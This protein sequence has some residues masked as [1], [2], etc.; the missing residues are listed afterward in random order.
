MSAPLISEETRKNLLSSLAGSSVIFDGEQGSSL[1]VAS[2]YDIELVGLAVSLAQKN[3]SANDFHNIFR[4]ALTAN[5]WRKM[6]DKLQ[7]KKPGDNLFTH[8][9]ALRSDASASGSITGS[10]AYFP[11]GIHQKLSATLA[12]VTLHAVLSQ[13]V[14]V[15][16]TTAVAANNSGRL[17]GVGAQGTGN[18]TLLQN[19]DVYGSSQTSLKATAKYVG[20]VT[21]CNAIQSVEPNA[22]NNKVIVKNLINLTTV[23]GA[24]QIAG[25]PNYCKIPYNLG[26]TTSEHNNVFGYHNRTGAALATPSSGAPAYS[27]TINSAYTIVQRSNAGDLNESDSAGIAGM[28]WFVSCWTNPTNNTSTGDWD[29]STGGWAVSTRY[30]E[31]KTKLESANDF[32]GSDYYSGFADEKAI[33]GL[34]SKDTWDAEK[35]TTLGLT[36]QAIVDNG[37][38]AKLSDFKDSNTPHN[39]LLNVL[40]YEFDNAGGAECYEVNSVAVSTQSVFQQLKNAGYTSH[41]IVNDANSKKVAQGYE[42]VAGDGFTAITNVFGADT[43]TLVERI[44]RLDS[45]TGVQT[46][47]PFN[48]YNSSTNRSVNGPKYAVPAMDVLKGL[49]FEQ[50]VD[51]CVALD[52]HMATSNVIKATLTASSNFP[53]ASSQQRDR[54]RASVATLSGLGQNDQ[55][56]FLFLCHNAAMTN[57]RAGTIRAMAD[58]MK[59]VGPMSDNKYNAKTATEV[60]FVSCLS[61]I[62]AASRLPPDEVYAVFASQYQ[63]ELHEF[64][65]KGK[66]FDGS[67]WE[68]Y[69]KSASGNMPHQLYNDFLDQCNMGGVCKA[70]FAVPATASAVTWEIFDQT[71]ASDNAEN[72]FADT[73]VR[74][75]DGTNTIFSWPNNLLADN[76]PFGYTVGTGSPIP[77]NDGLTLANGELYNREPASEFNTGS[78]TEFEAAA[79]FHLLTSSAGYG[80]DVATLIGSDMLESQIRGLNEGYLLWA[81]DSADRKTAIVLN[82]LNAL[83]LN[84]GESRSELAKAVINLASDDVAEIFAVAAAAS[85]SGSAALSA[86]QRNDIIS[87]VL[88]MPGELGSKLIKIFEDSDKDDRSVAAA[89]AII[90]HFIG[91]GYGLGVS[92]TVYNAAAMLGAN[93]LVQAMKKRLLSNPGAIYTQSQNATTVANASHRQNLGSIIVAAMI[94]MDMDD[95]KKVVDGFQSWNALPGMADGLVVT[96]S[97]LKAFYVPAFADKDANGV[98]H[99]D[100][101]VWF[102]KDKTDYLM[103]ELAPAHK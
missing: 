39:F 94:E 43:F 64:G 61:D 74:H 32:S 9:A 58:Y 45:Y 23:Y 24:G 70:A 41:D 18:V 62:A 59:F 15:N 69:R 2:D 96:V 102:N 92:S 17:V 36:Y 103:K 88:T 1:L 34:L 31:L 22:E 27:S 6:G 80:I 99:T 40:G 93:R 42:S 95:F 19:D 49:N 30:D 8:I 54:I 72:R 56:T 10:V 91:T 60:E 25:M 98:Y 90:T 66:S 7:E 16:D 38:S 12:N 51:L 82:I 4:L 73:L 47:L 5:A 86:T 75:G 20:N 52:N 21:Q 78:T 13:V 44:T 81:G 50:I 46:I 55:S 37:W 89:T 65:G 14:C 68:N 67:S 57:D 85:G 29:N 63:D 76:N 84:G 97:E 35:L 87:A 53:N 26:S 48:S 11:G 33:L 28:G 77:A 3:D 79:N 71:E 101:Y 83:S 100:G